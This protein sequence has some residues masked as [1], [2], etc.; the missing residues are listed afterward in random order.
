MSPGFYNLFTPDS[1][2]S[3][4]SA[5]TLCPHSVLLYNTSFFKLKE[6]NKTLQKENRDRNE[7][8]VKS[9]FDYTDCCSFVWA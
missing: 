3:R 8:V 2:T 7:I 6:E 9:G 5:S 1:C 4:D